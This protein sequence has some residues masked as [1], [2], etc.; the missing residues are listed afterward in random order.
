MCGIVAAL[1]AYGLRE[2]VENFAEM[3]AAI[4]GPPPSDAAVVA[5][6]AALNELLGAL[7]EPTQILLDAL[8]RESAAVLLV[9]HRTARLRIADACGAL[10][11]WAALVDDLLDAVSDPAWD[12]PTTEVVQGR[13]R[14]LTDVLYGLINDRVDIAQR[15][16]ALAPTLPG[17]RAAISYLAVEAVLAALNRLE[18]R[19]RDSAGLTIWVHLAEADREMTASELAGRA[20]PLF[21][22]G[23]AVLNGAGACFVYKRAVV[24]GRLGDNVTALRNAI[25]RDAALHELIARPSARVT[26][27]AHTRWA[28]VGR[29][30]EANAHPVDS[31]GPDGG[32]DT[33]LVVAALNGDVDNYLSLLG[34]AHPTDE[35]GITTDAKVVPVMLSKRL[36]AGEQPCEALGACLADFD[37]SMAIAVQPQSAD[38]ELVIGVKGSGQALY[39]G[40]GP[41]GFLVASEVSGSQPTRHC[42]RSGAHR[43]RQ[44]VRPSTVGRRW[45]CATDRGAGDQGGRS[46]DQGS[47]S[48]H[49]RSLPPQGDPGGTVI[50][51]QD[52]PGSYS[53][54]RD[55]PGCRAAGIVVAGRVPPASS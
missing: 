52:A 47:R 3:I 39:I 24:V 44:P 2:D 9:A 48:R 49:R 32:L 29:I 40:L 27:L 11:T 35:G 42:G 33:P 18:V 43:Q 50:V 41:S 6:P 13:L 55:G 37:G 34:S 16:A 22:S 36:A 23:A 12:A 4:P 14:A 7:L 54:E 51:P 31:R 26:V 17:R 20:D 45:R 30:S 19:G 5:D 25:A 28:S 10:M 15:A 53:P 8:G 21:R 1:P 46:H 38:G